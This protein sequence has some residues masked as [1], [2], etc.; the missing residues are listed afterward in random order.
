[1]TER[2]AAYE[3]WTPADCWGGG[4]AASLGLGLVKGVSCLPG[5]SGAHSTPFSPSGAKEAF[6]SFRRNLRPSPRLPSAESSQN[7]LAPLSKC[8]QACNGGFSL[9][10]L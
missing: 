2:R 7:L 10:A 3:G 6:G 5:R 9:S 8:V 1:M 4:R